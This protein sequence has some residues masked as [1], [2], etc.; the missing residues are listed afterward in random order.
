MPGTDGRGLAD[1]RLH[2]RSVPIGLSDGFSPDS[3]EGGLPGARGA[4]IGDGAGDVD[5]EGDE[6]GTG[7]PDA[8]CGGDDEAASWD[9]DEKRAPGVVM[10]RG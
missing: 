4:P 3:N 7:D 10:Y 8:V 9:N 6:V 2:A 5:A 1:T